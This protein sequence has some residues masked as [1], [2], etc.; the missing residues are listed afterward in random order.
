MKL[1]QHKFLLA[2]AAIIAAMGAALIYTGAYHPYHWREYMMYRRSVTPIAFYGKVVDQD[3]RPVGGAQVV[4]TVSTANGAFILGSDKVLA[5]SD[6][7]LTTSPDGTFALE[8]ARGRCLH[9]KSISKPGYVTIPDK[10]WLSSEVLRGQLGYY[11][12]SSYGPSLQ[13]KPDSANPAVFPM[14]RPGEFPASKPSRGGVPNPTYERF[15]P[16][17][18]P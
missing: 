10:Q 4:L 6:V 11:Y 1:R 13:Y 9:V 18:G 8:R 16:G 17:S 5:S 15:H 12:S 14:R 7:E 2:S 3:G